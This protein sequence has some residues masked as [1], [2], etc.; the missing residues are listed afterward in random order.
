MFSDLRRGGILYLGYVEAGQ[1]VTLTN[2]DEEDET[3]SIGVD[4]YRLNQ[5]VLEETLALLGRQ[6][7]ENVVWKS[8]FI[9]GEIRLEEAG[10][11]V[12]SVPWEEGWDVTINGEKTEPE[13]L[14]GCLMAFDLEPGDYELEMKYRPAGAAAGGIVSGVSIVLFLALTFRGRILPSLRSR[15]C[16]DRTDENNDTRDVPGESP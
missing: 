15:C 12:L 4:I 7:L 5:E 3:P 2:G 1:T 11:M 16:R 10:R 9:S 13:L 8:D 6:H 14:G